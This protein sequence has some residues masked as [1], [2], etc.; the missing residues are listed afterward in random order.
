MARTTLDLDDGVLRELK[1]RRERDGKPLGT[2]ASELLARALR[3]GD[4]PLPPFRWT[5]RS[6][7]AKVD[8]EDR[9]AVWAALDRD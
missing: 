6:M 9:E 5:A 1:K 4:E 8:L 2:I 7:K 3:E